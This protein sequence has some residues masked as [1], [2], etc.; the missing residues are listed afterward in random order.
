MVQVFEGV[1]ALSQYGIADAMWRVRYNTFVLEQ[2]WPLP[3]NRKREWDCYDDDDAAYI[4]KFDEHGE[5]CAGARLIPTTNDFLMKDIFSHLLSDEKD[6]P[7]GPCTVEFTR[8]FVRSDIVKTRSVIKITGEI[9]CAVFEHCLNEG[10]DTFLAVVD[11]RI[12]PQLYEMGWTIKPLGTPGEFGGGKGAI[13]GGSAIAIQVDVSSSGLKSTA[14]AR[15]VALPV[16]AKLCKKQ[17]TPTP[18]QH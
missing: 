8:Y 5:I 14:K 2:K 6:L 13:G 4:V 18:L 10:I 12:V 16:L 17:P 11:A 3:S 15:R 7:I 1:S 9:F